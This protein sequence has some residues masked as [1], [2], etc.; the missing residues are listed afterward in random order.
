MEI[1]YTISCRL[2]PENSLMKRWEIS[3]R[4]ALRFRGDGRLK[5][6]LSLFALTTDIHPM[7]AR[8]R[9]MLRSCAEIDKLGPSSSALMIAGPFTP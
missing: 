5:P 7:T 6:G 9:L 4:F 2:V 1:D 8:V 3:A